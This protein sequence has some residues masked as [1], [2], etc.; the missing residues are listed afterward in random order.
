MKVLPFFVL[1]HSTPLK[2]LCSPSSNFVSNHGAYSK[3]DVRL[4]TKSVADN[5]K[6]MLPPGYDDVLNEREKAA[7]EKKEGLQSSSEDK[8]TDLDILRNQLKEL[9]DR[10]SAS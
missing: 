5:F 8:L 2:I 10:M 7:V 6:S 9:L 4:K 3:E 1:Q